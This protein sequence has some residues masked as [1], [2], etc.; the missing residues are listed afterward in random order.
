MK[1]NKSEF[2]KVL[3]AIGMPGSTFTDDQLQKKVQ[4]LE[5]LKGDTE[6]KDD[7]VNGLYEDI[8]AAVNKGDKITFFDEDEKKGKGKGGKGKG[9]KPSKNGRG[10]PAAGNGG[11]GI[12]ASLIEWLQAA[13]S[14]KPISKPQ[15]LEKLEKRF[16]DR[17]SEG[18]KTTINIQVPSRITSDKGFKVKKNEKGYWIDGK[19]S[20]ATSEKGGKKKSSKKKEAETAE[21]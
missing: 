13:S 1:V 4:K 15:M 10:G 20:A 8:V 21:A 2:V 11:V 7:D 16:P 18:M 17:D 5:K 6:I 19:S 12:I 3:D 14:G 9:G